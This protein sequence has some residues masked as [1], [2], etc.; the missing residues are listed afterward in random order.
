MNNFPKKLVESEGSCPICGTTMTVRY[1]PETL[2]IHHCT[3]C[4]YSLAFTED[5]I[6]VVP[7]EFAK[8]LLVQ[9][10]ADVCGYVIK[11]DL[12]TRYRSAKEIDKE[13]LETLKHFFTEA[14]EVDPKD[15]IEF[16]GLVDDNPL[17]FENPR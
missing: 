8:D 6:I 7:T 5:H 16:L 2:T 4:T 12:S 14:G 1:S 15:V 10:E 13:Y 9:A 17:D 3:G 11:T